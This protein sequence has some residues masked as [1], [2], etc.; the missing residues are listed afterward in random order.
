[1]KKRVFLLVALCWAGIA[2]AQN[3]NRF[4]YFFDTDPGVGASTTFTNIAP[5]TLITDLNIPIATTSLLPGFHTLYIRSRNDLNQWT[6]THFRN[7]FVATVPPAPG[8]LNID[9]IEYFID[10]DPG[11]G[12]AT[13]APGLTPDDV[14]TN[15]PIDISAVPLTAGPHTFYVRAKTSDGQWTH[16]HFRN[17]F[18]DAAVASPPTITNFSPTSGNVGS[19]VII[20]GANFSTTPANNTVTFSG[21][22]ATVTA[23]TATS[24]TVTVPAGTTTGPIIV[25]VAGLN[26]PSSTNFTLNAPIIN[27][28]EYFFN[29]DPG[30]GNGIPISISTPDT[31]IDLPN[32]N[33]ITTSLPVGWHTVH[34]RAKDTNNTWGFYESRRIYVRE[35]APTIDPIEPP[36]PINA[37]EFFYNTDN[38]P[39]TGTSIPFTPVGSD[40]DALNKNLANTLPIGWHTIH[41][42]TKNA[43]NTWGFYESRR[44]YVREGPVGPP[45]PASP[46]VALE[47]FIDTDPGVG[48]AT[49]TKPMNP[50]L[51]LVDLPDEGLDIGTIA[52]GPRLIGLRAKNQAGE[53]SMTEVRNFTVT[54]PCTII[55]AP[56]A[57]GPVL[58]SPGPVTLTAAGAVTGETYRWYANETTLTSLFTGNPY[59]TPSLSVNTTYYVT[60]YNT[61]TFCESSRFAVTAQ[62]QG[63]TAPVVN[64]SGDLAICEGNSVA[65]IHAGGFP[66]YTWRRGVVDLGQN[67][68]Q[69]TASESGVYT[70]T[71]NNG[72]CTSP[73]SL[74]FTLTVNPKPIKPIITATDFGSLCADGIVTLTA[75]ASAQYLWSGGQTTQSIDVNI[76]SS[77][78]VRV[79]SA[80]GC[81]SDLSDPFNVISSPPD[82]PVIIVT[83]NPVLCGSASAQLSVPNTFSGYTWR[84]GAAIV[85]STASITVNTAGSYTV[86]VNNGTCASPTSDAQVVMSVA[87]PPAPTITNLGASDL[88]IGA[89]GFTILRASGAFPNYLWS[90]G[91]T[92]QEIIVNAPGVFTVQAGNSANCLSVASSGVSITSTG[93]T[94]VSGTIAAPTAVNGS[95]CDAGTVSLSA[96]GATGSQVYRWYNALTG[97]TLLFTGANYTSPSIATTTIYYVAIFDPSVPGESTRVPATASVVSFAAPV[98]AGPPALSICNGSSATLTAPAGFTNYLWSTG[99]T[100]QQ[101]IVNANGSYTVRV[102]DGTCFSPVSNA[103][104][105]TV[106]GPLTAPAI[107]VTG[108]NAN[109]C[110]SGIVELSAPAGF[111]NYLW[112]NGAT[113]ESITTSAATNYSV[114]VSDGVCTSPSSNII[115]VTSSAAPAKPTVAVTG[116]TALCPG[117]FVLLSAPAGFA[118]YEWSNGATE[119]LIEVTQVGTYTVRVGNNAACLSVPSDGIVVNN[120]SNCGTL[121]GPAVASQSQCAPG[122]TFSFT[123]S[124]ATGSQVYRWYDAPT[125]GALLFTGNPFTPSVSTTTTFHAAIYDLTTATETPRTAFSAT[126]VFI[127]TPA[128]SSSGLTI[129]QGSVALLSAPTGFLRYRWSDNSE[130]QQIQASATGTFTLQVGDASCF[131]NPSAPVTVTVS[132]AL[133]KPVITPSGSTTFCGVGSVILEAPAGFSM[134]V[135]STGETTRS[136]TASAA[137]NYTVTTGNGICTSPLSDPVNV[138][139]VGE[140]LKPNISITGSTALCNGAFVSL[141]APAASHYLWSNGS[142]DRTINVTNAGTY[143]VQVGNTVSCLSLRSDEVVVTETGQSCGGTAT[144]EAN[145]FATTVC[146]GSPTAFSD[147]S[148][149]LGAG[150]VYDWD[151]D[152]NG[153][154]D[155]DFVGNVSFTY[156]TSGTYNARLSITLSGGTIVTRTVSVTVNAV[157]QVSVSAVT[158]CVGTATA[159]TDNSV[160]LPTSTYSWDFE[161]D[162][163]EN[164]SV[165]GN[166]SFAYASGGV[167]TARLSVNNGN[168]CSNQQ[169]LSVTVLRT[170][171]APL[172][173]IDGGASPQL[174]GGNSIKLMVPAEPGVSYEWTQN[175]T[176]AGTNLAELTV[177]TAG[178]YR[179]TAINSCGPATSINSISTVVVPVPVSAPISSAGSTALCEG[180]STL[181]SVPFT[182]GVQYQWKL[183]GANIPDATSNLFLASQAGVHQVVFSNSC[184][185]V[186]SAPLTIVA[187]A[188]APAPPL[189]TSSGSLTL[190]APATVDLSITPITGVTYLWKR[191]NIDLN[192]NQPTLTTG[193]AGFYT[194]EVENSCRKVSSVNQVQV[195]VNQLPIAQL[196][197]ANRNPV[198]CPSE[199]VQL[200]VTPEAGVTYQWLREGIVIAGAN[201][202]QYAANTA[203][204]YALRI[205]NGCGV[206]QASNTVAVQVIE[207]P[208]APVITNDGSLSICQNETVL[209]RITP[210]AGVSYSWFRNNIALPFT[211]SSTLVAAQAGTYRV[212]INNGC[213]TV[214]SSNSLTV[215]LKPQAPLSQTI[216]SSANPVFCAPGQ[217]EL[218]VPLEAG[219]SYQ[220][221][222]NGQPVGEN[223][224]TLIVATSGTY[225]L[226]IFNSCRTVPSLNVINAVALELPLPQNVQANRP[227]DLC[228][229]ES[230]VLSVPVENS[231]S[232]QWQRNGI[233][234]PGQTSSQF[235]AVVSGDYRVMMFNG[236]GDRLSGVRQVNVQMPP[237]A[238]GINANGPTSF[239][240]GG[241]VILSVPLVA[242]QLYQWKRDGVNLLNGTQV[243]A[244]QS[245]LYSVTT[246]NLCFPNAVTST[247]SVSQFPTPAPPTI[248]AVLQDACDKR[249]YE[250]TAVGS[251]VGYQWF[252]GNS[253]LVATNT[254][255]YNPVVGGSY[256]VR[257]TDSNGCSAESEPIAVTVSA[258]RTP[259]IT[260]SG[261]PDSLLT[262]D[263]VGRNYQWYV[264]NRF[265][266]GA[267]NSQLSIFYN[268]EYKVRV[269]YEDGCRVF[270]N[271]YIVNEESY[272]KYGRQATFPN[273]TTIVLPERKFIDEFEV[274]P[275]PA[276]KQVTV[277]YFGSP[278]DQT[279]C[280]LLTAHG[281]RVREGV[282]TRKNGHLTIEFDVENL[283]VGLY[284]VRIQ[285]P[286]VQATKKIIKQ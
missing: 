206:V 21:V 164:S 165:K 104:S 158:A 89:G 114:V 218:S 131:S 128:I 147:L 283:E 237:L 102:G 268:G 60:R 200:N 47:W 139:V 95:R 22:A 219:A 71:V 16:T 149:N 261:N 132:P 285:N 178:N 39:G 146:A 86:V 51:D 216:V 262:T 94:C 8:T 97:G 201:A 112:S 14:L 118:N 111:A 23:S 44:I 226:D 33:F 140:L 2:S 274:T 92:A 255:K 243:L 19:T 81:Q 267:A 125:G 247:V 177:N 36:S 49:L 266:V 78:T 257:A 214:P 108:G 217:I 204:V 180:E 202:P 162:G 235:T 40:A 141:T 25:T 134:Y 263:V 145:F 273:D 133:A 56:T 41:V 148:V 113:T 32:L 228:E 77:H 69:I 280:S 83:G 117:G 166:T 241:S 245:G 227:T 169:L 103:I 65:L 192:I 250:L 190:C 9:R 68:N 208:L 58:C 210:I 11:V 188:P 115:A 229:G 46:I 174:C 269:T 30:P 13:E 161:N 130:T 185:S 74:P 205:T 153:S 238:A 142:T 88:C 244:Q 220:W 156:P 75:P 176:P 246:G 80:A 183:D 136:I 52:V 233:N 61:S 17:F 197:S 45:P 272:N 209:L 98:L 79:T 207:P 42:R 10:T 259:V 281:V 26:S 195:T 110:G 181:L 152:G 126:V 6:H 151:F 253:R 127:P 48:L 203:G 194:V 76:A 63:L 29:T 24:L 150:P 100:T 159:F 53:W 179:V 222:A 157:P 234:L 232:Y 221:K 258:P 106:T 286:F 248:S 172:I 1:M 67:I 249:T 211:N 239:C 84:N 93:Q 240:E 252:L 271:G 59:T 191:N 212:E 119:R 7:F 135:W 277:N 230:V 284:L 120:S 260:V 37:M 101:L 251:F 155:S 196:I 198:I 96:S 35:P 129:C 15:F 137:G 64:L 34:V 193:E 123:A 265:I 213:S 85:G 167:Y 12:L 160:V 184:G 154:R 189:I 279:V 54:A 43:L 275:N 199:I 121:T 276:R 50:A 109:I 236:C 99:A 186:T 187:L 38:G 175:G 105:V 72:T 270:S 20:N 215:E 144:P 224:N 163:V 256:K 242:G 278:T 73:P 171:S 116:S 254:V 70:L 225:S 31:Q 3:I 223:R 4:E 231:V 282:M 82:K 87:V 27:A 122:G 28:A 107:S 173:E 168:G 143:W 57:S 5:T 124:G 55:D 91:A 66:T 90:T 62:V 182:A 18:V 170:P 264:N 138:T